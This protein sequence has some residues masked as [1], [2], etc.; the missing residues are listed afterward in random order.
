MATGS[1]INDVL[2]VLW[3]GI[4]CASYSYVRSLC[5][6]GNVSLVITLLRW[7]NILVYSSSWL[8]D[9]HISLVEAHILS[10]R[11]FRWEVFKHHRGQAWEQRWQSATATGNRQSD[12]D[13]THNPTGLV[14]EILDRVRS[15][16]QLCLI[17]SSIGKHQRWEISNRRNL[18]EAIMTTN[19]RRKHGSSPLLRNRKTTKKSKSTNK[20]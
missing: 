14:D 6:W 18:A 9:R 8:F 10:C 15:L 19:E 1:C 3:L 20:N 2:I 5:S 11:Q 7:S 16:W 12:S 17:T 13:L 4:F